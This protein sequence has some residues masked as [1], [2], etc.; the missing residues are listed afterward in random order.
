MGPKPKRMCKFSDDIGKEY[1]FIKK[2][3]LDS[4]VYCEKCK[5]VFSIGYG[6]K[7]D[8][9]R[10]LGS[11]KH[12]N[13]L[14]SLAS[15]S[16][17]TNYFRREEFGSSEKKIALSEAVFS[18]HTVVHNQTFRSMDCTTKIIQHLFEKKFAC[19][20]TKT[21]AIIK[22][23]IA[24]FAASELTNDLES[25]DYVSIFSDASNHKD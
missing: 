6:G 20:R 10:H 25:L 24:P 23:V 22:K 7:R 14:L 1:P 8:I 18:F 16:Q 11:E 2:S 21:E 9:T 3:K 15:S 12:K 17:V 5:S 19:R 13:V 4:E